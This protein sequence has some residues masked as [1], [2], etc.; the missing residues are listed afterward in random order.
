MKLRCL[1]AGLFAGLFN[2][3]FGS[4]GG[5]LAVPMLQKCGLTA[6]QSHAGSIA[7][8][9]PLS[10]ITSFLLLFS[11]Q[12]ISIPDLLLASAAGLP[13]A[14]LGAYLLSR[15]RPDLLKRIFGAVMLISAVRLF[16]R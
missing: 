13:G 2:G 4:G 3:I 11:G 14:F 10:C 16:L 5:L 9:L 1:F 12:K 6:Q 8:T 7:V 15:I